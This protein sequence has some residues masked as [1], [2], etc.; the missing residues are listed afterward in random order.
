VEEVD[1]L[2]AAAGV[3]ADRIVNFDPLDKL[4]LT[5]DEAPQP[6]R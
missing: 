2:D 5:A 1:A 4:E 3:P 6:S